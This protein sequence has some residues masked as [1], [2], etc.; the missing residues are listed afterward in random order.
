MIGVG[1][2]VVYGLGHPDDAQGI[3]AGNGL[4]VQFVGG[5]LGVVAARV[6]EI[7]DVVSLENFK[8]AVHVLGGLIGLFLKI[9]LVTARCCFAV[10]R[11][12]RRGKIFPCSVINLRKRSIFL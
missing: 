9:D 4:L 2:V 12:T 6:E 7:A 5:V 11:V 3:I 10:S 8:Q 1:K